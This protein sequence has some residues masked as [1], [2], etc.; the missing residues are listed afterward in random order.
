MS[1]TLPALRRRREPAGGWRE[2]EA[3]ALAVADLASIHLQPAAIRTAV[4]RAYR[5]HG[6]PEGV[7]AE[8][9]R[10]LAGPPREAQRTAATLEWARRVL[11]EV[12][13]ARM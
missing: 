13:H 2:T 11:G 5:A 1:L 12:S 6:G 4:E 3:A 9:S 8:L 10:R 7:T